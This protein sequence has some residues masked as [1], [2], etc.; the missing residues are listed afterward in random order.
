[1]YIC[2]TDHYFIVVDQDEHASAYNR[3]KV[4]LIPASRGYADIV[5]EGI[6]CTAWVCYKL[7]DAGEPYVYA[8]CNWKGEEI[9]LPKGKYSDLVPKYIMHRIFY[10]VTDK[11]SGKSFVIDSDENNCNINSFP[12]ST[13]FKYILISRD[14]KDD[15]DDYYDEDEEAYTIDFIPKS[16]NPYP[17]KNYNK[18]K[19]PS[20][21]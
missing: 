11:E 3:H 15:E 6:N 18:L 5:P 1:M 2:Y 7:D 16:P 4:C 13:N 12:E 19:Q 17:F 14:D 10:A 9:F 21:R 8:V 20:T